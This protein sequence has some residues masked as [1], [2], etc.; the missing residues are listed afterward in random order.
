[1]RIYIGPK[2][3]EQLRMILGIVIIIGAEYSDPGIEEFEEVREIGASQYSRTGIASTLSCSTGTNASEYSADRYWEV[4]ASSTLS[5]GLS[6][7]NVDERY[8]LIP[9][10]Y[11]F[12]PIIISC[13]TS[14]PVH[15]RPRNQ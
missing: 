9:I 11:Y 5:L 8:L 15:R 3:P 13:C 4:A 12:S 2:D 14:K 10:D 7:S 6:E 1:M